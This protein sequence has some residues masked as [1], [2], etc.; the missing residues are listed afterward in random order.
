VIFVDDHE[1]A[2][3]QVFGD[4]EVKINL[5]GPGD[6]PELVWAVGAKRNEVRR[7]MALVE[8]HR[9]DFAAGWRQIHG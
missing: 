8:E 5:A 2:H 1:P 6:Q 4:G 3:V 9:Q 7:A